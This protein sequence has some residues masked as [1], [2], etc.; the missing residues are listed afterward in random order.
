MNKNKVPLCAGWP[1]RCCRRHSRAAVSRNVSSNSSS[2]A[3]APVPP[4]ARSAAC[5]A[6]R[7][8]SGR[9]PQITA[10][11][12]AC[13]MCASVYMHVRV[14]AHTC[15]KPHALRKVLLKGSLACNHAHLAKIRYSWPHLGDNIFKSQLW[16]FC[17]H[18]CIIEA[19]LH[20]SHQ[21]RTQGLCVQECSVQVVQ[22]C[23]H[24]LQRPLACQ[25]ETCTDFSSSSYE[26]ELRA[27]SYC[28]PASDANC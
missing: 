11:A 16:S 24:F 19:L 8:S 20:G 2:A 10:S 18:A 25:C 6:A 13:G 17:T 1:H 3:S 15:V 5:S 26:H 21:V 14:R 12:H 28:P 23:A 7:L 22:P 9:P 4:R 27:S